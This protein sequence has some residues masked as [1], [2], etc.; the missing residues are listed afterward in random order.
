MEI[1]E[2]DIVKKI[3]IAWRAEEGNIHSPGEDLDSEARKE[4]THG[5]FR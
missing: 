3:Y 4:R 2:E 1:L 5:H